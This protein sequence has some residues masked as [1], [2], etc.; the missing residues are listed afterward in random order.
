MLKTYHKMDAKMKRR[1][2]K[3]RNTSGYLKRQKFP[4][5]GMYTQQ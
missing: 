4:P 3:Q 2:Q 5:G 1:G